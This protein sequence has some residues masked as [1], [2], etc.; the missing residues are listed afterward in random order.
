M[1]DESTDISRHQQISLVI[2]FTDDLFNVYD[3]FIGFERATDTS[4]EGL[5]HL[6]MEW[7]NK[8]DLDVKCIVSQCFDGA[9]SMRGPCKGVANRVSQI[10][11]TA[12]YVHCNGHVLNLCLVD[13]SEVV[14]P[15]RNNF[16]IVKSLYNL[17]EASPKRH[18]I[19]DDLQKEAGI[20]S[21]T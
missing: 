11:P 8:L 7:L 17:I 5:F 16:G 1:I 13:V 15:V 19:F 3:R 12:L 4:G 10:V 6:V 2:R 21:T 9:S 18:K 20:V 14:I